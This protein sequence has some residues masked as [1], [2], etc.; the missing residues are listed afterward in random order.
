M[1]K[2]WPILLVVALALYLA[3]GGFFRGTTEAEHI[4]S[5]TEETF[6]T[7]V[8]PDSG[9]VVVDFWAPWCGPCRRLMPVLDDV[10]AARSRDARFV[11]VNIDEES[12]LA[13]R[14]H[15]RSIPHVYL[16]YNGRPIDGFLGF[17]N[18][19]QIEGW[20]DEHLRAGEE[21]TS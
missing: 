17:R 2:H 3:S 9:W 10:A 1:K 16:F 19:A 20:M 8:G 4:T 18:R 21:S 15:I 6:A 12:S 5:V 13:E 7:L 14:F 11:K